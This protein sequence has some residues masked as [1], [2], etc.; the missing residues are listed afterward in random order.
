MR[1]GTKTV[2][3]GLAAALAAACASGGGGGGGGEGIVDFDA[4]LTP[5]AGYQ[6][7]G[8]ANA[9]S[10]LGRTAVTVDIENGTPGAA[11]PWHVHE[12]RCGTNG[13][14]VGKAS[15][16]S[17]IEVDEDGKERANAVLSLVLDDDTPYFVNLH[18]SAQQM[19]VIV[20]CGALVD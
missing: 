8:T 10:T 15:D 1:R 20:S 14:I 18:L 9:V 5:T 2:F 13:P 3:A 16:Y 6:V 7:R 19:N 11:Y 17:P 12:G 4:Q